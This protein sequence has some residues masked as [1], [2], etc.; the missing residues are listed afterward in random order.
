M[1]VFDEIVELIERALRDV[2]V[3]DGWLDLA[4]WSIVGRVGCYRG[5]GVVR[6]VV[7]GVV[8]GGDVLFLVGV[9]GWCLIVRVIRR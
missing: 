6:I 2:A 1:V 4:P 9:G 5:R 8:E 7:E 3:G